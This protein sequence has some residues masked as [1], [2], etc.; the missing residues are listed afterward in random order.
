MVPPGPRRRGLPGAGRGAVDPGA[1]RAAGA[2]PDRRRHGP[3]AGGQPHLVGGHRR[4]DDAAQD[5]RGPAGDPAAPRRRCRRRLLQADAPAAAA[6][7]RGRVRAGHLLERLAVPAGPGRRG[8]APAGRGLDHGAGRGLPG[9]ARGAA[10][11]PGLPR[12]LR[13]Q[14]RSPAGLPEPDHRGRARRGGGEGRHLRARRLR[15]RP[16]RAGEAVRQ[17]P[18]RL[19]R[20]QAG[21]RRLDGPRARQHRRDRGCRRR[22]PGHL[23]RRARP[24][25]RG[26]AARADDPHRPQDL[27][28]RDRQELRG[29]LRRSGRHGRPQRPDR[30]DGRA[31]DVRPQR[32]GRRDQ[33]PGARPSLLREGR[34]TTAVPRNPGPV[35][36]RLDLEAGDDR[37]RAVARLQA[38]TPGS[39]APRPSRSATGPSRTT[40]PAPTASSASTRRC[41]S[42]ATP[43]STGSATTSGRGTAPTSPT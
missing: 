22:H 20:L 8:R 3:P 21:G 30:G 16:R 25:G 4:P 2:R 12:A 37:G 36:P 34:D 43:S 9:R 29:R 40:S 11:R 35:R 31:A 6:V 23:H 32:L 1:R 28:P 38:R 27:R 42:P 14:R 13:H 41:R 39:T 5:V 15:G 19:P 26:A 33:L 10:E 17:V 7:R 24:G 18:P